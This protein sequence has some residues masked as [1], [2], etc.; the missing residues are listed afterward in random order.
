M[1]AR[2]GYGK[3]GVTGGVAMKANKTAGFVGSVPKEMGVKMGVELRVW[4]GVGRGFW[5]CFGCLGGLGL[6]FEKKF[7]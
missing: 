2:E 5:T 7:W 6:K 1:A 4:R 3:G